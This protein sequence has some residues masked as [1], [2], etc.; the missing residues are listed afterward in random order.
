MAST[1]SSVCISRLG[2]ALRTREERPS[3]S[4]PSKRPWPPSQT[5]PK[6][7]ISLRL[8]IQDSR[9]ASSPTLVDAYRA[10]WCGPHTAAWGPPATLGEWQTHLKGA[11][12]RL[13]SHTDLSR[14]LY[15][16]PRWAL[17]LYL[18]AL[19]LVHRG[20]AVLGLSA[21]AFHASTQIGG[22]ARELL[23]HEGSVAYTFMVARRTG[24]DRDGPTG[25][26]QREWVDPPGMKARGWS[27][28][29]G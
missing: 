8:T 21:A 7:T 9:R 12:L 23:L 18:R 15:R 10:H 1:G 26:S 11:R 16:R 25:Q 17:A 4:D 5:P 28:W 27:S 19:L 20:A 13:E 2:A 6:L 3:V 14:Q 22:V 24:A 29:A